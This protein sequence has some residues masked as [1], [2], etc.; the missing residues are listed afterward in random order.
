MK[1]ISIKNQ[2][3][4]NGYKVIARQEKQRKLK[5]KLEMGIIGEKKSRGW[6]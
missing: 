3:K 5:K 4:S 2:R 1:Q 6:F